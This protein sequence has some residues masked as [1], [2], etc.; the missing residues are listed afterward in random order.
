MVLPELLREIEN[1]G[2]TLEPAGDRLRFRPKRNL[3]PELVEGLRQHKAE[4]LERLEKCERP[5]F[6][7]TPENGAR[8]PIGEPTIKKAG[9]VLEL[10]RA[11][12]GEMAP[13]H[14]MDAPYPP[15]ESGSDPMM[16]KHTDKAR[17]FRGVRE[18]DRE[19]R[20]REGLPSHIRILD[21][22]GAA[23]RKNRPA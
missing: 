21:G 22:G 10:A 5:H 6:L 11:H 16:H 2:V 12:F 8:S 3:T 7:G 15:P 9:E 23:L 1:R 13:E 17:F 14:Q 4:I 20:E 18:R 19:R